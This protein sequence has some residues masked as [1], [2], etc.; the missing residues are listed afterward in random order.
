MMQDTTIVT[1]WDW[2]AVGTL[3]MSVGSLGGLAVVV[4]MVA[5]FALTVL[6]KGFECPDADEELLRGPE[7]WER[8]WRD[9]LFVE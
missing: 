3:V 8:Y 7:R 1:T 9:D 4:A 6:F 5:L 2:G